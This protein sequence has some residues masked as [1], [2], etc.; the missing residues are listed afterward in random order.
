MLNL[1]AAGKL[2]SA[3]LA[4][5]DS[6]SNLHLLKNGEI[7]SIQSPLFFLLI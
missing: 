7:K 2:V 5:I 6:N 3:S 1:L 4:E